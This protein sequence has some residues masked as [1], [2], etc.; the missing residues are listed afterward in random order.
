[1]RNRKQ[2]QLRDE[3]GRRGNFYAFQVDDLF[4]W[5]KQW[6]LFMWDLIVQLIKACQGNFALIIS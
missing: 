4:L 2:T 1:M 3:R 6:F 5:K